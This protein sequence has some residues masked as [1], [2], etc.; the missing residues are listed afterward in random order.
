MQ[1]QIFH[2]A[3]AIELAKN[4]G[5]SSVEEYVNQTIKQ[6]ADLAAIREGINDTIAGRMTPLEEFDKAFR[7]EMSFAK[8]A[9][10]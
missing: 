3:A 5:F 8:R 10:S 9:G 1:V 6:A 4:A 2:E 7:E